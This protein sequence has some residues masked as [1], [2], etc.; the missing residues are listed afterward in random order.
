MASLSSI[1]L[2]NRWFLGIN[3]PPD[4]QRGK[5]GLQDLRGFKNLGGLLV[6]L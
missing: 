1:A 4:P 6:G 2:I 5:Y 3:Q